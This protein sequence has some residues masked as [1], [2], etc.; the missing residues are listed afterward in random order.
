[1]VI[2]LSASCDTAGSAQVNCKLKRQ[3]CLR[4][5]DL[6]QVRDAATQVLRGPCGFDAGSTRI[7]RGSLAGPFYIARIHTPFGLLKFY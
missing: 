6:L 2:V 4:G 1:M 7:P 3:C 5:A